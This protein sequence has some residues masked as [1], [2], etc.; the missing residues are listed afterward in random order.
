[1]GTQGAH[2]PSHQDTY[3]YNVVAQLYGSKSWILVPPQESKGMLPTRVPYEESSVYS[4]INFKHLN[5][6]SID[7]LEGLKSCPVYRVTLG[8]GDVLYVPRNWWHFVEN[9]NFAIS[10]N[11][12]VEVTEDDESR[13]EEALVRQQAA[14]LAKIITREEAKLLLNPNEEDLLEV[15]PN[16][17]SDLAVGLAKSLSR[18][19]PN[20]DEIVPNFGNSMIELQPETLNIPEPS[21]LRT[22][23]SVSWFEKNIFRL[24]NVMTSRPVISAAAAQ[25]KLDHR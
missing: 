16:E 9:N 14:N 18:G 7:M 21:C 2:T 1:M 4:R 11:T 15:D 20:S 12:W 13:L 19:Q 10:V 17:L 8:P 25:L 6:N 22:S 24:F 3:G 23:P 5:R